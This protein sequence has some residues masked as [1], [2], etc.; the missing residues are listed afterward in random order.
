MEK[1]NLP[2]EE[3]DNLL[4]VELCIVKENIGFIKKGELATLSKQN[5]LINGNEP[6]VTSFF[7]TLPII[8]KKPSRTA[9]VPKYVYEFLT[10]TK[11]PYVNIVVDSKTNEHK[12]ILKTKHEEL[13]V[14]ACC[15][16]DF[17]IQPNEEE[18]NSYIQ[19]HKNIAKYQDELENMIKTAASIC[20]ETK[21]KQKTKS[22]YGQTLQLNFS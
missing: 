8:I 5:G 1:Y 7:E 16:E 11:L 18:I 14:F 10:E 4:I 6:N 13:S 15:K 12:Y 9:S 3:K 17:S 19:G 21:Q 20:E 2:Q 22:C